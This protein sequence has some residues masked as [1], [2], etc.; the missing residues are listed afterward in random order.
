MLALLFL[1]VMIGVDAS[2]DDALLIAP[3]GDPLPGVAT[4]LL[5]T[6]WEDEWAPIEETP[7][8][9]HGDEQLALKTTDLPGVWRVEFMPELGGTTFS[10]R[11]PDGSQR[12]LTVPAAL[13]RPSDA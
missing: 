7:R 8:L 12:R 10:V 6:A 2:A 9:F 5:L 4:E 11:L 1:L 3:R 13:D